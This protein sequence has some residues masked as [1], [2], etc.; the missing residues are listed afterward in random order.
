MHLLEEKD[1]MK[2]NNDE[3]LRFLK[4]MRLP[5]M[6]DEFEKQINDPSYYDYSFEE[7]FSMLVNAEYDSRSSHTIERYIKNAKFY[8]SSASLD[9]VD[10]SPERKLDRSLI[11][12]LGTND[13][14]EQGL[15]ISVVGASGSGKTWLSCAFGVNACLDKK[16]VLYIR[17]P[18]LFSEMEAKKIQGNYRQYIKQLSK[19][20][21]LI[22]DDFLITAVN[23]VEALHLL[24]IFEKRS[25]KKS[26]ILCSQWS[27]EGWHNK[28]N[29]DGTIADA[30]LDR[31]LNSSYKICL[32]GH[33]LRE[34][35][36]KIKTK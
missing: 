3:L 24:E 35:Y 27:P 33:S 14:I 11:E 20:D 19:Y 15:S 26:T 34:T 4:E 16:K 17:M 12:N 7:R 28:I 8:D 9:N 1:I 36:S 32:Y 22:I 23:E 5:V 6:A 25:N 21:L 2:T 18:E 13:Y 30:I 10:Y 31:I 29:C